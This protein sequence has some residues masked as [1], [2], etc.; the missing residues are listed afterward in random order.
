MAGHA[1]PTGHN[2]KPIPLARTAR[3]LLASPLTEGRR[4]EAFVWR[5]GVRCPPVVSHTID[6]GS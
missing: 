2:K 3:I 6:G 1:G 5:S 4:P